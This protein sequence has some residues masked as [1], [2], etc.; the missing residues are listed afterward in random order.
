MQIKLLVEGGAMKLGPAVSQQLGPIGINMNKVI[1]DVNKA[2]EGFKGLKVPVT[3]EID[4]ST[5]SF[6]VIVSSPPISELLKKEVGIQKGSGIQSK[7]QVANAS[8]EQIISVAKT[9]LPTLLCN[10]LK[11]AVLE[12]VG[13]CTSLGILIEN[14][15]APEI[16]KEIKEGKYDSEINEEKTE[17]DPEKKKSLEENFSKLSE[18]QQKQHAKAL[19]AIEDKKK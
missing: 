12:A 16:S 15:M 9:K 7:V 13:T 2:T 1:Q 10:D 19:E 8:I 4:S 18:E 14:K 11:A 5:K 6:E 3:L 17:T